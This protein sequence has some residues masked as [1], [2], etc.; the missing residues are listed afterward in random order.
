MRLPEGKRAAI[1]L[2]ID[3]IHPGSSKDLYEAG[4]DLSDGALGHVEWLL[5]RHPKLKITLFVTADW[6]ETFPY[7]TK[8]LLSSLPFLRDW[9]YLS[10]LRPKG[11][12]ALTNHR[13]FVRFLNSL[14]RVTIGLHGL[15][16]VT[17]GLVV[18]AELNNKTA[19]QVSQIID[20]M[21]Q[22]FEEAGLNYI[23]C[24]APPN[25]ECNETIVEPLLRHNIR[26]IMSGRDV[27]A[28]ISKKATIQMSGL[29]GVSLIYPESV[30]DGRL[31]HLPSN[32]HSTS[33]IDRAVEIIELGG[34]VGIK[35]H[36]IKKAGSLI[37][38]DGLDEGYRNYLDLLLS[39]L[40][41]RYSDELWWTDV[42]EFG[43]F[44]L[45]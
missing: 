17:K 12:M 4:G 39:E 16:H 31:L 13:K 11:E 37:A 32:F 8:R 9:F 14:K 3:D 26:L 19:R 30:F 15:H 21:V 28:E 36:I 29:K 1:Y 18:P 22:I 43:L 44:Q 20:E 33:P 5:R 6:R 23:P 42:N 45:S 27:L 2:T 35:A 10:P 25:W 7:P 34:V 40:D 24:F 38:R 41:K